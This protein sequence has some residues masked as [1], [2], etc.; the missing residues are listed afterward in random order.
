MQDPPQVH[1]SLRISRQ[2]HPSL[3]QAHG[4]LHPHRLWT[5][6]AGSGVGEREEGKPLKPLLL[7]PTH[8][9]FPTLSLIETHG[10]SRRALWEPGAWEHDTP[11][12]TSEG[13]W[14][15]IGLELSH[16]IKSISFL[17]NLQ[18]HKREGHL[19]QKIF[20]SHPSHRRIRV[21]GG[22]C[23]AACN[24]AK[25]PFHSLSRSEFLLLN[26]V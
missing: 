21:C 23:G 24:D 1:K 15:G 25:C 11:T 16:L 8:L 20:D 26:E 17:G 7:P 4:P 19:P 22:V 14:R 13:T 18:K 12:P 3:H 6:Q 5:H 2:R 9:F 10:F